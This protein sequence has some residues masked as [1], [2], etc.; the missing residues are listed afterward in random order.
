[1]SVH[2]FEKF[3]KTAAITSAQ[4]YPPPYDKSLSYVY[5][6]ELSVDDFDFRVDITHDVLYINAYI[7]MSHL[8]RYGYYEKENVFISFDFV[9]LDIDILSVII[10]RHNNN[11]T[12]FGNGQYK[13][14]YTGNK[15]S[16]D[17]PLLI[18]KQDGRLF[19]F[20]G[21]QYLSF[22]HIHEIDPMVANM[23]IFRE[24]VNSGY[25]KFIEITEL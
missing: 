6:D 12:S 1:M 15:I 5:S 18:Y 3:R 25:I 17:D 13:S 14:G 4:D 21:N 10:R 9:D 22:S 7:N 11:N 23:N 24:M 16:K 2:K 19:M 8:I 20:R